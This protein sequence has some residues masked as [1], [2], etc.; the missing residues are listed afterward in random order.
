MR[1][2][3][4]VADAVAKH[5]HAVW[6]ETIT[7]ADT[8]RWPKTWTLLPKNTTRADL[9]NKLAA[10]APTSRRWHQ[11]AATQPGVQ[12]HE[13][14]WNLHGGQTLPQAVT[15]TDIAAAAVWCED[16]LA[17]HSLPWT[18][19]LEIAGERAGQLQQIAPHLPAGDLAG[20]LQTTAGYSDIDFTLLCTT[21]RWFRDN[22]HAAVG[23]TPRQVPVPGVHAKWLNT[24]HRQVAVLAGIESLQLQRNHPPRIHF[25]YLDPDHL[26]GGGRRHDM[27]ALGDTT[28]LAYTPTQVLISEN[29]DTAVGFPPL[30]GAIAVEGNGTEGPTRMSVVDWVR[31][32]PDVIYWGDLD[33]AGFAI[34]NAYRAAG[35]DVRTILM[36]LD[37]YRRYAQFGTTRHPNGALIET[38]ALDLPHLTS[39]ERA[40]YEAVTAGD[41]DPRRIEQE[42]IPLEVA[43]AAVR[44]GTRKDF[45][46]T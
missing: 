20:L 13:H 43:L 44:L 18:R 27:H 8:T 12:V 9:D 22:H 3:E 25:T 26:A 34:I 10:I 16:R 40:A 5:L 2:P 17:P 38:P 23:L 37:A 41:A 15:V 11:L 6:A 32:C 36:D 29:K 39:S 4:Q 31:Q 7:G 35:L 28:A 42:R 30:S 21:A 14:H 33:A 45:T 46:R 1:T 19:W 24:H